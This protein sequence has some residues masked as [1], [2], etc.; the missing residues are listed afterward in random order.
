M[1]E[2]EEF[3][4]KFGDEEK[5]GR[6]IG[7]GRAREA[8]LAHLRGRSTHAGAPKGAGERT[9]QKEGSGKRRKGKSSLKTERMRRRED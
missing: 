2:K 4:E 1:K 9:G 8:D 7:R 5:C 6:S 3:N